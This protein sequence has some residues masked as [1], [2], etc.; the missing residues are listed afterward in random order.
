MPYNLL[1]ARYQFHIAIFFYF[2]QCLFDLD[3]RKLINHIIQK[4]LR[5]NWVFGIMWLDPYNSKP[6]AIADKPLVQQV[7][8]QSVV[9]TPPSGSRS[10]ACQI[11]QAYPYG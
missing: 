3:N 2:F 4:P 7:R 6:L 1:I 11:S 5:Q 8:R 9:I 10:T